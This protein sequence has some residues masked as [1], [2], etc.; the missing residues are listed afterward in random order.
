MLKYLS[1]QTACDVAFGV[2]ISVWF[3]ARHIF[4]PVV[5]YS[6]YAHLP[7]MI[8]YTCYDST[9]GK[10]VGPAE[11]GPKIWANIMQPFHDPGG[12]V[13]YNDE[14]R[15]GFLTVLLALLVLT[16]IWFGM[17]IRVAYKVVTGD[18]A[19]DVR[20][21]DEGEDE[22]DEEEI[23]IDAFDHIHEKH[24]GQMIMEEAD[25][26]SVNL[27]RNTSPPAALRRSSRRGPVAKASGISIPGHGDK[28]E[29]LG[30]IGCDKPS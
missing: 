20:S 1:F 26:E 21:D 30:R 7:I 2:F 29:L 13:C 14:I 17:I 6:V 22:I 28:K 23:E 18:G 11:R 16:L 25:G 5:C 15:V 27:T 4:Y 3:I 12:L 10:K 19:E 8:P 24:E 9:T